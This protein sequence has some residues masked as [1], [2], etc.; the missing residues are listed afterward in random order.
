MGRPLFAT[1]GPLA[2]PIASAKLAAVPIFQA[3][4]FTVMRHFRS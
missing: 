4:I 3:M 1:A 2:M